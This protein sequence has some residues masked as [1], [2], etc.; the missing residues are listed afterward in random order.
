MPS[1]E[2][3]GYVCD[4]APA[5]VG[6][7]YPLELKDVLVAAVVAVTKVDGAIVS[8]TLLVYAAS[9]DTAF[10]NKP[11]VKALDVVAFRYP[12]ELAAVTDAVAVSVSSVHVVSKLGAESGALVDEAD[13]R[14]VSV[15]S[16][17]VV[18]VI[19]AFEDGYGGDTVVILG[20]TVNTLLTE[21]EDGDELG[22]K[23]R[24]AT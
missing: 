10:E 1:P 13:H 18:S 7:P 9:V 6:L 22:V 4:D 8:G 24:V 2:S 11:M 14:V 3:A 21:V 20:G 23:G 19:V 5:P 12:D 17:H 16:V 15:S